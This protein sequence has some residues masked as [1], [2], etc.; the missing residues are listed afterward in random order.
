MT[1]CPDARWEPVGNHSGPMS[2]HDGLILHVAEAH[3][4]VHDWFNNPSSQASSTFWVGENGEL[5][6]YVDAD[7]DAWAQAGGNPTYNS[8]ETAGYSTS[9]LTKQQIKSLA[10]LYAWGHRTYGWPLQLAEKPGDKGFG[11][12]GMGGTAWGGHFSCPGD[13]RKAQR[14]QILRAAQSLLAPKKPWYRRFW[15]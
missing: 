3:Q 9:G 5:V 2:A 11:W 4:D 8:V 1:R 13:K 7:E 12:H 15:F 14:K 10:T 6:Q